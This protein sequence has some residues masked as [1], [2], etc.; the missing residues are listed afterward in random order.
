MEIGNVRK[1]MLPVFSF[2]II[3]TNKIQQSQA[4]KMLVYESQ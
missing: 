1:N 4:K 3:E 2:L